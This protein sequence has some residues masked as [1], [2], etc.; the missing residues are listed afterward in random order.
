MQTR[1][2]VIVHSGADRNDTPVSVIDQEHL[3]LLNWV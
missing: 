2:D 1:H 3:V